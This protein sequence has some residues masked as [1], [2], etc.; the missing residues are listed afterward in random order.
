MDILYRL[1]KFNKLCIMVT[2]H[3]AYDEGKPTF[4]SIYNAI[5]KIKES[6]LFIQYGNN[7]KMYISR[8]GLLRLIKIQKLKK[9][10]SIIKKLKNL[11][12]DI[13]DT[14]EYVNVDWKK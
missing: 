2:G 3:K 1:N 4:V 8:D 7:D 6:N 9:E 10:N 14:I 5:N 13:D 12:I 11:L